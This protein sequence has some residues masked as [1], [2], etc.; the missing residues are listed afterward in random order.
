MREAGIPPNIVTYNTVMNAFAKIGR[1][2]EVEKFYVELMD[3]ALIPDGY[4]YGA[5]VQA[6]ARAKRPDLAE[7]YF[8][9]LME[10]PDIRLEDCGS[11]F[12][13]LVMA[14]GKDKYAKFIKQHDLTPPELH[15]T[16]V[17][18][19]NRGK[20]GKGNTNTRKEGGQQKGGKGKSPRTQK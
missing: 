14:L 16:N 18:Q 4:T 20:G 2:N 15:H 9:Q 10:T 11:V 7:Q 19:T 13:F 1:L 17:K 8:M 5:L 6:C 12:H 3:E